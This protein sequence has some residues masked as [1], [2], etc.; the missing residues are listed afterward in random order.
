MRDSR[1]C[2][3][4]NPDLETKRQRNHVKGGKRGGRGRPLSEVQRL[5]ARLE[6]IADDVRDGVLDRSDA[7]V[8]AQTLNYCLRGV[9]IGLKAREQEE[10]EQRLVELEAAIERQRGE[11]Y[12]YAK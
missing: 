10:L 7:A 3:V 9:S 6:Q 11:R 5:T 2:Y 4:H 12:G 8:M 1:L